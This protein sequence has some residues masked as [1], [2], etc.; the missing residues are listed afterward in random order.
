MP[1]MVN[2]ACDKMTAAKVALT[3]GLKHVRQP[4]GD[5]FSLD[6]FCGPLLP[7]DPR[8]SHLIHCNPSISKVKH[9]THDVVASVARSIKRTDEPW[10]I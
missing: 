10:P 6:C 8:T 9:P 7:E 1:W 3:D 4:D 5:H 2:R